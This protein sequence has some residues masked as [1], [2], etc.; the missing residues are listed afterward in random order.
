M[1]RSAFVYR[2]L[3]ILLVVLSGLLSAQSNDAVTVAIEGKTPLPGYFPMYWDGAKG[4]LLM[5]VDRWDEEFLYINWLSGGV[6]SNDLGLDRGKLGAQRIVRFHRVGPKVLLMQPNYDYRASSSDPA[7]RA[8]VEQSF[9]QAVVWGFKAEAVS[10]DR[11]LIDLTDFALRD[12]HQIIPKL[13]ARKEGTFKVDASRSAIFLERT[14]NFPKNSEIES[15]VTYTTEGEMGERLQ[16]VSPSTSEFTVRLHHSFVELPDSGYQPRRFDP[17]SGYGVVTFVD[18]SAPI[19]DSLEKRFLPRH[20][21][22]KKDPSAKLSDPVKPIV[23]YVD[24]GAPEPIRSALLE[25]AR[26]W[27]QAFEAAGYR[28]AFQVELMPEGADPMDIRYNVIQWVHRSTRGWSYG[29]S[30]RDPRTGE[31]LKGHVTLGSRRV[32]QDYLIATGLLAPYEEG[33]PVSPRMKEMALARLRQ[34]SA[35]EVGHTLGLA[36]NFAASLSGNTSVMDYPHPLITLDRNGALD[37]TKAYSTGIGEWDKAT[38]AYGYQDFP[39][40]TDVPAALDGILKD[41]YGK[42]IRYMTDSDSRSEGGA[43]P[44]GH[45]WDNGSD[46][47]AELVR[48][49]HVRQAAL[50]HFSENVLRPGEPLASMGETLVPIYLLHRYQVEAAAKV[51][52]GLDYAYSVRGSK[53]DMMNPPARLIARER[54]QAALSALLATLSPEYLRIPERILDLIPPHPPGFERSAESFPAHT[55]L[56]FD[57]LAAAEVAVDHTVS[58]LLNPERAARLVQ[59]AARQNGQMR[60]EDVISQLLAATIR[61]ERQGGMEGAL[62]RT[63]DAVVLY[64]L[65]VLANSPASTDEVKAIASLNLAELK[66]F[67]EKSESPDVPWKAHSAWAAA[68]IGRFETNPKEIPIPKPEAAP[69]GQPIGCGSEGEFGLW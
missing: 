52:G 51:V 13:K 20:R 46:P 31:I 4:R 18:Y 54:Q 41:V 48:L 60:L 9:A 66:G 32:R 57:P 38:I 44:D 25:G 17:R 36:H 1:I 65:M 30:V 28:N 47:A 21:L 15:T 58:F 37:L 55:G 12:A 35:H 3:L 8:A 42:G 43:S 23:Y 40:G 14:K 10:G 53:V 56:T 39:P 69:P 19:E 45:L 49:G 62:Q 26:W 29:G 67:F 34:L 7:E 33:K 59:Y 61:S 6:G 16:T 50:A 24:R 63:A 68:R 5:V 2:S 11:V 22:Q 27:N 64:R